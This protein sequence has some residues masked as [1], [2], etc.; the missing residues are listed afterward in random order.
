MGARIVLEVEGGSGAELEIV[1]HAAEPPHDRA[2]RPVEL[3]DRRGGAPTCE[4]LA[5]AVDRD[6]VEM[7]V[8]DVARGG[9]LGAV[10]LVEADVVEAV[11]LEEHALAVDVDLLDDP[12]DDGG[13]WSPGP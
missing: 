7:E 10:G 8:V 11:P 1:L 3:V 2:A 5:V 13:R 12:H 9:D 4:Q 6:R